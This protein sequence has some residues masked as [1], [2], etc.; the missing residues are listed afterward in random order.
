MSNA[1]NNVNIDDGTRVLSR[2]AGGDRDFT[3][4]LFSAANAALTGRPTLFFRVKK[5]AGAGTIT[6]EIKLN[7]VVVFTSDFGS[8]TLRGLHEIVDN[9]ILQVAGNELVITATAGTGTI[10]V[11]DML[12]YYPTTV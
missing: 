2:V 1:V 10:D 5:G 8:E 6:L 4:P 7:N 11:S 12:L 9:N 3:Y